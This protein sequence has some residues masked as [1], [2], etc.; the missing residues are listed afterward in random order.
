MFL[1][2]LTLSA[3][4][5]TTPVSH[6]PLDP[7]RFA[8]IDPTSE[9]AALVV[10]VDDLIKLGKQY[11]GKPYRYRPQAGV[12][13]DCSGYLQYL[14]ARYEVALPRTTTGMATM[15]K[16]IPLDEVKKGD[17]LFF[18]GRNA[19]SPAV[20]HVTMV[21]DRDEEGIKMMHSSSRGI[22]IDTYPMAYY[23]TRFLFAGRLPV[24]MVSET[25]EA[26]DPI[27]TLPTST[28]KTLGND[29]PFLY[30]DD[31]ATDTLSVIGVGDIM[32]GTN[33]PSPS[34]L[35]PNDGKN[36]L[37]PVADILR[38][39]D[40][41]FGNLEGVL[42]TGQGTPKSCRNPKV[43]YLFKSP[44]H[45]AD[46]L[47]EAG[48]DLLSLA[49]NH[50]GD[51]GAIGRENTARLL[52][53]RSI[54]AAGLLDL[55]YAIVEK[56]SVR[57]GL[58]AFAPNSGTIS[59]HD[60]ARAQALIQQ[61]SAESDVVIVSFHGGAEG[62][63]FQ[64]LTRSNEFYLGENRGNPYDFARMAIDAGAD[65]VFGH[66]PHVTRAIDLYKDRFIAYSLGNFATYGRFNLAGPNGRAPIV[67]VR[68]D[69]NGRFIDAE[70]IATRQLGEGGPQLDPT[71][72]VI[73]EIIELTRQDL[74]ESPLN[75]SA[76]GKV[77]RK[78]DLR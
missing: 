28:P 54:G 31:Q 37:D 43:C 36:L 22:V 30:D 7:K 8:T 59:I 1:M 23:T 29:I 12:T 70:L 45:Y 69:Q 32:L 73:R 55:P 44:D 35:P 76:S 6:I 53:E 63:K 33:Y 49:N 19:R 67:R 46:Y 47:L 4:M 21:I 48:F 75:I 74:P 16:R 51:F 41:T 40:V 78:S 2:Y 65:I 62:A 56:D 13:M 52:R 26:F 39:A 20:G 11:L 57:Y 38:N 27:P 15:V 9:S 64:R 5:L 34:F 71:G 14:F 10:P 3:L 24:T 58:V 66:G 61:V 25:F 77:T 42:L 60:Y 50:V 18:R 68:T 17:L 72:A